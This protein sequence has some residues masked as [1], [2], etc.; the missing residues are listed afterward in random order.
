MKS[1]PWFSRIASVVGASVLWSAAT[2]EEVTKNQET[3]TAKRPGTV[4]EARNRAR[5]LH[6]SF[7]GAL[8]VMHRDFFDPDDRDRIP[9]ATLEDVFVV[10]ARQFDVRLRWLG[11]NAKT[12]DVDH[13]PQDQFEKEAVAALASGQGEFE[14]IENGL[15]R[16]A[17]AIELHNQC[18]KCHVPMR[19]RLQ[20]RTAGL[21]ISMR[22][23]P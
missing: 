17:G 4:E 3:A 18:L 10:L 6:E 16:F 1:N 19:T 13:E 9:S 5:L 2:G 22:F 11:V 23:G 7:H 15:Y 14:K 12:M 20:N 21:V 8:Q